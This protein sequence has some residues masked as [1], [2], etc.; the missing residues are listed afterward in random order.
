MGDSTSQ[1][2]VLL[3]PEK[4]EEIIIKPKTLEKNHVTE[5][6]SRW[7]FESRGRFPRIQNRPA[8]VLSSEPTNS[9]MT[10]MQEFSEETESK[11]FPRIQNRS[12]SVL[13]SEELHD[14]QKL[15]KRYILDIS[16]LAEEPYKDD[17]STCLE[18]SCIFFLYCI[19][20]SVFLV[21]WLVMMN[22]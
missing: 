1:D 16:D 18:K 11:G 21:Y 2:L 19:V 15:K 22:R 7:N 6:K 12:A 8:S 13:P 14:V 5:K 3:M 10:E 4:S 9:E 17:Y 20:F